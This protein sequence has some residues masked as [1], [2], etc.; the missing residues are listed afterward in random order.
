MHSCSSQNASALLEQHCSCQWGSKL[1]PG[2]L[3]AG[4]AEVDTLW[5]PSLQGCMARHRTHQPW[6]LC[7]PAAAQPREAESDGHAQQEMCAWCTS[8]AA[9]T[10]SPESLPCWLA[11]AQP[12]GT[13]AVAVQRCSGA[14]TAA[15]A[16]G[17]QMRAEGPPVAAPFAGRLQSTSAGLQHAP[18]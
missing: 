4:C 17:L 5:R 15:C 12:L 13:K 2:A 6:P 16:G 1:W 18:L 14:R 9:C 7:W 3:N 11:L 10:S 8:R